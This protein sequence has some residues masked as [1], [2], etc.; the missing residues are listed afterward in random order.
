MSRLI[1]ATA[2]LL[3]L[4]FGLSLSWLAQA[5]EEASP[6]QVISISYTSLQKLIDD[7]VLVAGMAEEE[8]LALMEQEL[9]PVVD[10]NRIARKVMGKFSR[11]A[12]EDQLQKFN[13]VFKRTLVKTYSKGLDELDKLAGTEVGEAVFD[14]KRKRAKVPSVI[15]LKDGTRYQ[16]QYSMFLNK[17]QQWKVENIIVEGVNIGLVF[18][19]QFA[20]YMETHNDIDLAIENWGTV[21]AE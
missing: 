13:E 11:R 14:N 19:N 7:Q 6:E 3:V 9:G 10:F 8:L 2:H 21:K 17:Q 16:V 20:H 15:I 4:W 5:E 18:R 12:S 1:R